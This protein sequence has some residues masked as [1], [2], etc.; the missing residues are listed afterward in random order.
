[1][2]QI[3]FASTFRISIVVILSQPTDGAT[4]AIGQ[5]K[6]PEP[7]KQSP[8]STNARIAWSIKL[9][10]AQVYYTKQLNF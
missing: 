7:R 4:D 1:M 5:M 2:V 8:Q 9:N 10:N 3:Q 6:Y